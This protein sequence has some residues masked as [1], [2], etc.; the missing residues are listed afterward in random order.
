MPS[1]Q[2]PYAVSKWEAELVLHQIAKE[3]GIEVVIVRPPLVYGPGVRANFLKLLRMV[4]K[5]IPLPLGAIKSAQSY[6]SGKS[7]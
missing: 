4:D 2:D 6:L 5:G 1:P 7:R 3:T